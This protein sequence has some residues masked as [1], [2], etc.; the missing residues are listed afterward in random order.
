MP[1]IIE[2][3]VYRLDELPEAARDKARAWYREGAFDHDWY[4][5]VYDDFERI[6]AIL[7]VE[8]S[9]T[10]VPLYG[11]GTRQKPCIWFSG[12]WSQGDGACFEGR[13]RHAKGAPR[14][15]RDHAPE[16]GEL[17]RIADS[18]QAIQR[19]NFY[20]LHAG[21]CHRDR[22]YHEYTMVVAVERDSPVWQNMTAEAEEAVTET[23]RDLARWLYRQLEREY[24]YLTSDAVVDEAILANAYTFTASGRRFG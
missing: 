10:R 12:F 19:R 11:G 9:T 21:I 3:T 14:H 2:T 5:F 1:E 18:L 7:G 13:Y 8:L 16:D 6:C 20:Q 24:E 23:L 4:E 22:Y 17:H 15:I